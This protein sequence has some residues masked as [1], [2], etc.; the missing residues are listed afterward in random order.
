MCCPHIGCPCRKLVLLRYFIPYWWLPWKSYG[1]SVNT[2]GAYERI[3]RGSGHCPALQNYA[4][5]CMCVR[6]CLCVCVCVAKLI[7]VTAWPMAW[8]YGRSLAGFAGSNPAGDT[9][10]CLLGMFCSVQSRGLYDGLILRTEAFC[11]LHVSLNWRK[12]NSNRLHLQWVGG[13]GQTEE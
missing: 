9:D 2:V 1:W 6:A 4:C 10:V 7:P 12:C 5:A 11:R 3:N 8:V 13:R